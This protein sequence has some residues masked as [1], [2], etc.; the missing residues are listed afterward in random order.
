[1]KKP[2]HV[3]LRT[4]QVENTE[5]TEFFYYQIFMCSV[6]SVVKKPYY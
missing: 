6:F 4:V 1:M 2:P 5:C 3:C